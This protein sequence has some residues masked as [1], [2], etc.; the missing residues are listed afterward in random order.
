MTFI[1]SEPESLSGNV[2]VNH[3]EAEIVASI[4]LD[5][6]NRRQELGIENV[7]EA[8]GII[9]PYRNQ[10][11][12]IKMEL[13][14]HGIA[15]LN[16]L[17][18]DTVE[19]FQGSERDII[20]YSFCVNSAYQLRFLSNLTEDDGVLIDRKLNV[21]LTRARRQMFITGVPHLLRLNPIYCRLLDEMG[22]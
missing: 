5:I 15:E 12:L 1:P 17:L 6:Y 21:A 11:A 7:A 14:R 13:S 22:N 20:I 3:C 10:I 9:T 18:V 2:K 16:N 8:V 19:R 4:V